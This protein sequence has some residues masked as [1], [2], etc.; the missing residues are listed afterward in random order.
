M[1]E[2]SGVLQDT[3]NPYEDATE[4][5]IGLLSSSWLPLQDEEERTPY[6]NTSRLPTPD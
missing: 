1:L 2:V 4:V 6:S 3:G 5:S